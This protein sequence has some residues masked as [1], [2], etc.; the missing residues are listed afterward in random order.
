MSILSNSGL[1]GITN[2]VKNFLMKTMPGCNTKVVDLDLSTRWAQIA[3]NARFEDTPGAVDKRDPITYFNSTS[4][5]TGPVTGAY[6]YYTS[7]GITAW[8]TTWNTGAYVGNDISGNFTQIRSGLTQG[9]RHQ[10]VVYQDLL[11]ASNGFDTPWVYDG[12]D[13]VTWELGAC[14]AVT[15]LLSTGALGSGNYFYAVTIGSA[16][17]FTCG[18]VSNT[19]TTTSSG[20]GIDS[21]VV[22]M[23]HFDGAQGSTTY[24]DSEIMPKTVTAFG[25]AHIDTTQSVFGGA[26]GIFGGI[27][28]DVDALFL[29]HMNGVDTSTAFVDSSASA[30]SVIAEGT[31]QV[32][33]S[34]TKFGSGSGS[35]DGLTADLK[36][37]SSSD[38]NWT[39]NKTIDFWIY[40]SNV[41]HVTQALFSRDAGDGQNFCQLVIS[42]VSDGDLTFVSATGGV[43]DLQFH[44]AG[45]ILTANT[46]QHIALVKSGTTWYVFLNG[47]SQSLTLGAGSYSNTP[48]S[49]TA[50]FY[51][52]SYPAGGSYYVGFMDEFRVSDIARWTTGFVVPLTE[53]STGDYVSIP[54]S[55]DFNLGSG[56]FTIDFRVKFYDLSKD[57]YLITQID[58][59]KPSFLIYRTAVDGILHCVCEDSSGSTVFEMASSANALADTNWHHVAFVRNS[60]TNYIF[61]DGVSSTLLITTSG[62]MPA[63]STPL[64]I[65]RLGGSLNLGYFTGYIDELRFSKGIARWTSGFTPPVAAY[66]MV[67]SNAV[68]LSHIP[69]GPPGTTAR[70]LYRTDVNG[71][72]LKLLDTISDN[73]TTTYTDA[74]ADGSLGAAYPSLSD[75]MP[76]GAYLTMHRE[77]LFISGDPSSPNKIYY[78]STY[79]PHYI[80]QTTQ[81]TFLDIEAEDGDTISGIP[82]QLGVMICIKKNSIRK[83]HIT[84]PVSG[85]D[86]TT[87]YADDPLAWLGSPAPYSITQTPSG[88]VFLGW[89]HWYIFD[90]ASAQP[91]VDEF[92]INQILEG[93]FN[94]V[95]GYYN[96]GIFLAAYTDKASGGQTHNRTLR[97]NF[98]RQ[99]LAIDSWTSSTLTG[100]NCFAGRTGDGEPGDLYYGDSANGY[101]VKDKESE[102]EYKLISQTDAEAGTS[103]NVFIGGTENSPY[104]EIGNSVSPTAIPNNICIFWDNPTSNPGSGWT[105]ILGYTG[106]CIKV[107][108]TLPPLTVDN[109]QP[110]THLLTGSIPQ[111]SGST[112]NAGDGNPGAVS[113]HTHEVASFSDVS[114][115]LPRSVFLRI[116]K[117]NANT[118]ENE[119]PDGAIVMYDQATTPVGWQSL[120]LEGFNGYYIALNQAGTQYAFEVS[121]V[122]TWPQVADKYTNNGSV[123][124]IIFSPISGSFGTIYATSSSG[125]PQT[126]GTLVRTSGVGD[127]SIAFSEWQSQVI[128]LNS[129]NPSNHTHTFDIP[130]GT[131]AGSLAQSDSG[132]NC[133]AFG[134]DH[135][136][137]GALSTVNMDTWEV[138]NIAFNFIKKIGDSS[139]WDGYVRNV[140]SLFVGTEAMSNGWTESSTYDG[141][142]LKIGNSSP[143]T[144]LQMNQSHTHVAGTFTTSTENARWG[145]G[146]YL[147]TAYAAPHTHEVTLSASNQDN[148]NPPSVSFRLAYRILGQMKAW[149]G[150]ITTPATTGT[151]VSV[152]SQINAESLDKFYWNQQIISASDSIQFY[153]RTGITQEACEAASWS[154]AFTNPNGSDISTIAASQWLQYQ[155]IFNA[156]NTVISNPRVYFTNG[157]AIRYTYSSGAVDAESSVNFIYKVGFRNFDAPS[158]DK[159]FRKISTTHS[160][161]AGSYVLVWETE[162]ANDQFI[163]SLG[164]NP[165]YWDSYFQSTAMGKQVD[166]TITKNDLN[167]FKLK[168]IEGFY[169]PAQVII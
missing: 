76:N 3:Q 111:W 113:A 112:V 160:G 38:F 140:Y 42:G 24:T 32:R 53:Y 73:S 20:S 80:Q 43:S 88:I 10:F 115:P 106:N 100:A 168:Q 163:V 23:L 96:D 99:A 16:D 135:V 148:G 131:A 166:V 11:I 114:T 28:N 145:N 39:T 55:V 51:V 165:N 142:Y 169:A 81:L 58:G 84:S 133:P 82:I 64:E 123:F 21:N 116:F 156:A 89:D 34:Q 49:G 104:L 159:L 2:Q 75:A 56:N 92:D 105:E 161:S 33:T 61:V 17:E 5:G 15:T 150:A 118:V 128:T 139:S 158:V 8:I 35:F 152:A 50:P 54:S 65:G 29:L 109:G 127:S 67:S 102:N 108:S 14:K 22:L 47:V 25:G 78:S 12:A 79:L 74:I 36:T 149:N 40:P 147:A 44:T 26:S 143:T 7:T 41:G 151:Y 71:T 132:T 136:I 162:N 85:A 134:H 77:R 9:K 27:G 90:G 70:R 119:F 52:G 97:W 154:F 155:I 144:G 121:G 103:T 45:G 6:R 59:T 157:Y 87:W 164:S 46:W 153:I 66:S 37:T 126:S 83:L 60:S 72:T 57:V 98:R 129:V 19:I 69:L 107:S 141:L 137:V 62:T 125:D 101:L 1:S 95:I 91:I 130:T 30:H 31:A 117:K 167:P 120:S 48:Y 18:T 94:D 146:G 122:T 124:T 63:I 13:N 86:P 138:P 93:N 110:H 4:L 68:N